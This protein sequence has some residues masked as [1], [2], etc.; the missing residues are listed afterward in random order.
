MNGSHTIRLLGHQGKGPSRNRDTWITLAYVM[1]ERRHAM[2]H[3][4]GSY[5]S[6]DAAKA[7]RRR[8]LEAERAQELEKLKREAESA[9]QKAASAR[10][11]ESV[12]AK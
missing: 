1:N 10:A 3:Y 9:A 7:D 11:R 4:R 6:E 5:G 8:E 12:P 2:C